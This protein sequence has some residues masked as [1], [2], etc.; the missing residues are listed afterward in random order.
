[1]ET[2]QKQEK[3]LNVLPLKD[4]GMKE[5]ESEGREVV[6]GSLLKLLVKDMLLHSGKV[7][8]STELRP[9]ERDTRNRSSAIH[10]RHFEQGDEDVME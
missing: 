1:M 8:V 2:A 10:V 6:L 5:R 7:P 4:F 9:E 3:H